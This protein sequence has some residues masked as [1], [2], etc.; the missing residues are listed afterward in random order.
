MA[1]A[2]VV[3]MVARFGEQELIQL[4]DPEAKALK[5]AAI[6]EALADASGVM[7]S[8]L[9][10]RY[11][12]PLTL[13]TPLPALVDCCADLALYRL[14]RL[15]RRGAVEDAKERSEACMAWLK[16]VASGKAIIREL[17]LPAAVPGGQVHMT[18]NPRLFSRGGLRGF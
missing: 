4:S 16:D 6:E 1:Y 2:T 7:D 17:E 18:S 10:R 15:R 3:Q 9:A 13:A 11:S 12:L 8:Y 14:M 5:S